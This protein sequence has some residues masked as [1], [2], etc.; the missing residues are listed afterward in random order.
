MK[1]E[2]DY[3][4]TILRFGS[5]GSGTFEARLTD[6]KVTDIRLYK[7][8]GT[9]Q[10]SFQT[11]DIKYARAVYDVLGELFDYLDN[12]KAESKPKPTSKT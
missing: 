3:R 6:N 12:L 1:I 8:A 4:V 9:L 10:G 11:S 2:K 7:S 5:K